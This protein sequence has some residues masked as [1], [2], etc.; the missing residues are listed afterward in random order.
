M[1]CRKG[2]HVYFQVYS[3][4]NTKSIDLILTYKPDITRPL[5]MSCYVFEFC[6]NHFALDIHLCIIYI[7]YL[8]NDNAICVIN[9]WYYLVQIVDYR[10][11]CKRKDKLICY[12]CLHLKCGVTSNYQQ[13]VALTTLQVACKLTSCLQQQA[14]CNGNV[15]LQISFSCTYAW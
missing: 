13:Q 7:Y 3:P 5:P 15:K 8:Q 4:L 1:Q 6:N 11:V 14:N 12:T 9:Y 10:F 2:N